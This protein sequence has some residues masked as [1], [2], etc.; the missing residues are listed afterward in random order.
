VIGINTAMIM[1][2]QGI[3]FSVASNTARTILSQILRHG[4]VRRAQIGIVGHQTPIARAVADR[5]GLA[6]ASGVRVIEVEGGSP[7]DQAGVRRGDIVVGL[8]GEAVSG[9]DDIARLLDETR[10]GVASQAGLIR[11]GSSFSVQIVPVER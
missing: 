10:I 5:A 1:G 6:S 11:G 9:V 3:C 7:A 8:A 2:A 4:R